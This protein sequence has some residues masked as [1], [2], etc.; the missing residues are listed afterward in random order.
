MLGATNTGGTHAGVVRWLPGL[1]R[2]ETT[3]E[4][5]IPQAGQ[6]FKYRRT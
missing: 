1:S 4:L 6:D 3:T 2:E 5:G